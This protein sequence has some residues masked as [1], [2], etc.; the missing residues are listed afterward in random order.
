MFD[1]GG[2]SGADPR[3]GRCTAMIKPFAM[4]QQCPELNL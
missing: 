3:S 1:F 4:T 2:R